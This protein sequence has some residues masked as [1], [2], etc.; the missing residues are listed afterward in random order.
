[1]NESGR[2]VPNLSSSDGEHRRFA[3]GK[4]REGRLRA[5]LFK[6]PARSTVLS[7]A[8]ALVFPVHVAAPAPHPQ[9]FP[10]PQPGA[11]FPPRG[12]VKA[13]SVPQNSTT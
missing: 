7:T 6:V 2:V 5:D 1:M 11:G 12:N 9:A 13:L 8:D 4:L 10:A 3:D